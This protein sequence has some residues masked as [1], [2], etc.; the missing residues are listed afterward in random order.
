VVAGAPAAVFD[1]ESTELLGTRDERD[2][3]FAELRLLTHRY[4]DAYAHAA[5]KPFPK[6]PRTQL[7]GAVGVVFA[8][9]Q[10]P[11]AR[12]YRRQRDIPDTIGTAVTVQTMVYGNAGGR[13]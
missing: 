11:R 4:L 7:V 10:S 8:S 9:W 3:D 1:A 5:G 12:E 2:L 13:S 6:D